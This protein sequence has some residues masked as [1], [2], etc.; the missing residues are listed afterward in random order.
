MTETTTTTSTTTLVSPL[1]IVKTDQFALVNGKFTTINSINASD[2]IAT[3]NSLLSHSF[4]FGTVAPNETSKIMIISLNIPNVKAITD[5]KIGLV[6]TG[7]IEFANDLF[8]ITSSPELRS[9]IVPDSYFQGVNSERLASS[10]LNMDIPNRDAHSSEYVY[11]STKLPQ[12][13]EFGVGNIRFK[14]FFKYAI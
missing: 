3:G 12:N 10:L 13:H 4:S 14:W 5:I 11:L 6:S 9:D 2:D 7:G 8:A 1:I